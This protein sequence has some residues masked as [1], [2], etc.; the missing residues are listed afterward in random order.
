MMGTLAFV[1]G[2]TALTVAVLGFLGYF[3]QVLWQDHVARAMRE[4][5]IPD[6]A[7]E[8]STPPLTV[9]GRALTAV[10][11]C[12]VI[13]CPNPWTV[14]THGW[15]VCDTHDHR[16]PYDRTIDP[17]LVSDEAEAWLRSAS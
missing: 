16:A 2:V 11:E 7:P 13:G 14:A 9:P 15:T 10:E 5:D 6:A 1:L 12:M 4:A 8:P 17:E 3:I